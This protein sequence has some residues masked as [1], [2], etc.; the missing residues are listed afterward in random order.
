MGGEWNNDYGEIEN[1]PEFLNL[2]K[3][4]DYEVLQNSDVNYVNSD[5]NVIGDANDTQQLNEAIETLETTDV[6]RELSNEIRE[7]NTAIR[8]DE[9][10]AVAQFDPTSNEITINEEYKD[11]DPSVLASHLAH[12]GTHVQWYGQGVPD[13][14]DQEYHAFKNEKEVWD[15]TKEDKTDEQCDWV[16]SMI[17]QGEADAKMHLRLMY[18]NLPEYA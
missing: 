4:G 15:Q 13:S 14:I 9:I 5:V 11:A 8:F 1:D 10:D 18:P 7:N 3:E 17:D 12:E 2:K 6:G 16:S